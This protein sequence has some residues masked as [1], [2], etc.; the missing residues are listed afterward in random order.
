MQPLT[1]PRQQGPF[2]QLTLDD[3]LMDRRPRVMLAGTGAIALTLALVASL[4]TTPGPVL[5]ATLVIVLHLG[6]G[7]APWLLVRPLPAHLFWLLVLATSQVVP[8]LV[9]LPMAWFGLWHPQAVGNVVAGVAAACCALAVV[10][11]R[12]EP[13]ADVRVRADRPRVAREPNDPLAIALAVSGAL[14]AWARAWSVAGDPGHLGIVWKAGWVWVVGLIMILAA[15]ALAYAR[16]R[17]PVVPVLLMTSLVTVSQ[18]LAY[19]NPTVMVAGRHLGIVDW[20]TQRGQ[21]DTSTD[22]YQGWSGLFAG[23]ALMLGWAR[24]DRPFAYAAWWGA[25]AAPIMVIGVR[26]VA[27]RFV[28]PR[29]AWAAALVFGLASSLTTSFYAPQVA[30]FVYALGILALSVAQ[31]PDDGLAWR[32]TTIAVLSAALA[33]THQLSPYMLA[34]ALAVL[35]VLHWVRPVWL[36]GLVVAP[37]AAWAF[38]NRELMSK[39]VSPK[40]FGR[41]FANLAPPEHPVAPMGSDPVNRLTFNLPALALVVIGVVALVMLARSLAPRAIALATAA[42]SPLIVMFGTEYGQEGIFRVSLFALPW[43]ATLTALLLDGARRR[44]IFTKTVYVAGVS[45][46][47]VALTLVHVVGTTGMDWARVIRRGDV[48]AMRQ[49][50]E[51]ATPGTVLVTLGSS[52]NTPGA[53]TANYP[54]VRYYSREDL[55]DRKAYAYPQQVGAAYD[56]KADLAELTRRIDKLPGA[57]HYI[58]LSDAMA[59]YQHRYGLQPYDDLRRLWAAVDASPEW[60]AV[61]SEPGMTIYRRTGTP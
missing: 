41:I 17:S 31:R 18:A 57:N 5:A 23:T 35:A 58:L 61:I 36:I 8:T 38:I 12:R 59:A 60:E 27:G 53:F 21:L 10:R 48:A 3:R 40:A 22:I 16:R 47:L 7:L 14:I 42:A 29:R 37:A 1:E 25:L 28:T 19:Q 26:S 15:L 45:V 44:P 30:G 52:L 54:A 11:L 6:V 24:F 46:G 32:A 39:Y 4:V 43:L 34:S 55:A 49:F 20:I 50:E 56:P 13:R 2:P 9:G 51:N 33:V